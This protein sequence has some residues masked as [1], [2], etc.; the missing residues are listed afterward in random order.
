MKDLDHVP[1]LMKAVVNTNRRMED[2]S[3][4]GTPGNRQSNP[5]K[6]SEQFNVIQESCSKP[7]CRARA[8]G[9]NIVEQDL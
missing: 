6:L 7:P 3:N 4:R 2:S 1:V 9:A 5:R 8:V